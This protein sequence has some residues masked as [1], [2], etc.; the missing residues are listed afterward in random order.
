MSDV[1]D[2]ELVPGLPRVVVE[3]LRTELGARA[4]KVL[5]CLRTAAALVAQ[6]EADVSGLRL[7]ESAAYNLREALNHVVEG[8]D[9]A[10]GGLRAV[11]GA[12]RRFK[13]QTAVPGVDAA[14]AR[15]ELDQV[16]NRVAADE[17][18]ASYYV[19]RLV[20]YLQYR[21]GV[22]PLDPP[23]DP[24]SEYGELR[25]KASTA[26]HDELALA[27]AETLLARTVAWFIR[28]FTP[29]DQVAGAIRTLAA[30][31]WSGPEQIAELKRLA[32][33]DHHL[34]LFFSEI[35]DPAWLEPLH[36]AGVAH[37]PSRNAPWPVAALLAGLGKTSPEAVAALLKC[38]LVDTAAI[39]K[40]ER[41]AARF[42][43]LRIATQLDPPAHGV[44]V[45]VVRQHSDVPSVRS[46][47]VN[48]ALKADA[49]DSAVL[50]VA[51]A[52]LNHFRR[53]GDGDRYHAVTILDQLQA[54]VTADNVAD[55]TRMLA[56]KTRRLARSDD[57]RYVLLGIEA[58]TVHPGE[59]PEPL[60]LF[61][62]HLARILS[63][64]RQWCV[65]T[66]KQL[67]WLGEMQGEVGER[68][69]GH[70]LAGAS[71]VPVTDKIAHIAGRLSSSTATAEDLALVTDILSYPPAPGDLAAWAGALGT[72]S[73]APADGAD[74]IPRDWARAWRWA[75]VLPA[76][77]L[78]AWRDAIDYVSGFHGAPD[79]QALTGD[80]PPRWV[81]RYG[82]SPYNAEELS[83]RPPLETAALVA[84]WEP[85]AESERQMFGHLELARTLEEVVKANPAEW[86][87]APQDVV[88]ALGQPLYIE[89]Y[90][91]ALTEQAADIVPQA[92]A[93]LAAALA[94]PPA[95][96]GQAADQ[97]TEEAPYREDWQKV[98]LDLAKALANKDGD[99]AASLND[100]W[101]RALTAVRSVP[102]SDIGLLFADNDPLTSAINRTWG[103]GLQTVL[104]LAAW[105]F[106]SHGTVRP[107]FEQTLNAVIGT[108]GSA[109]LEFRAI[110]ASHRP[111]LEAIAAT[112]LE[113]HAAALFREGTLA[114]ETFDLTVK[115]SQP[116]TW[117]YR[118][119]T[120][121]LFGAALRGVDNAIRLIVVAAL[122]EVEGYDLDTVINRLG[123]GT[124]ALATAA[125][126]AAFLVQDAEPDSPHITFA[127]RFWTLLLDT[128]RAKIPAQALTGL[129]RWAFVDNVDD[130][131]WAYLTARTLD[132][133][134]GRVDDPISVADRAARLPPSSTSRS[135][136]LRLLDN[137]EPWER[138][139]AAIKALDVL[140]ACTT[141]PAD[142]SFRRL[143]TRLIDLGHHEATTINPPDTTE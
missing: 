112:W 116:T 21:A 28:V 16:L 35:T 24:V 50:G 65:P 138:H 52:V 58:L 39:A 132:A 134:D 87:A 141:Q 123:K 79:P 81:F 102:E 51:D 10:E 90:F 104:A 3:R 143:R 57:A 2:D 61:A 44:V 128:G 32:T 78:T 5:G 98:V 71:D 38:L 122:H 137:G 86:S 72:P 121:E 31:P 97:D 29:P 25:D 9:A 105:E 114:Q 7:A 56:G 99:L 117:L 26:V 60:L 76:S 95:G 69:R 75:A 68:L 36:Q 12:W 19:R 93:V 67:E 140:R 85:D 130:D 8:Q 23:G 64:A 11:V 22:S 94:Q 111:L 110:L 91:R 139:H 47:S 74:Q 27:E 53:F 30:Q 106:R 124:A 46:L 70:A 107:E 43:L 119:F 73:P 129:G 37:L 18:R 92:P 20:A 101:E 66:S 126:D 63:K 115:W 49:A 125:E 96:G 59:H 83:A 136:L 135:I 17:S 109:G 77:V 113:A 13:D 4:E 142:D 62:H 45:E 33:V 89:H 48:A 54:G 88:T 82:R 1:P 34:R 15:D 80:R 100:L 127:I 131:Q 133:T 42:E 108:V 118:E 14:A 84:A 120:D 55:R 41:A 103:H 40:H 6:A